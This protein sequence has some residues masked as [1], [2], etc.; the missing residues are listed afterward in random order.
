[1]LSLLL[2][3]FSLPSYSQIFLQIEEQN[4]P[5]VQKIQIGQNLIFKLKA[6]PHNWRTQKIF[7]ILPEENV[8]IFDEN[9][10]KPE[11]ISMLRFHRPWAKSLGYKMMQFSA[12]WYVYGG[13]GTLGI[14]NYTMS[15]REILLGAGAAG[16]GFLIKTLF[17]KKNIR[18][19]K[20]FNLRI[21]DLRF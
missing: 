11:E 6:Y 8:I 20:N 15:E 17:Y 18:L 12:A 14:S 13:L 5:T 7:D 4:N 10:F 2:F 3:I 16:T 1:L 9:F 21:V 19:G